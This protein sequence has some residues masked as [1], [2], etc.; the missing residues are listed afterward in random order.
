MT[1]QAL[2]R[3]GKFAEAEARLKKGLEL[4]PDWDHRVLIWLLLAMT[5]QNL[6]RLDDAQLWSQRAEAARVA[7]RLR[8][9]GRAEL[10][11][12]F[13]GTG[14]GGTESFFIFFVR[15]ARSLPGEGSLYF[16]DNVFADGLPAAS[17]PAA[18]H[19]VR[20]PPH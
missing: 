13:P 4:G 12:A 18:S 19:R 9:T 11:A 2:Y 17:G 5:D 16:P 3:C 15:E 14:V 6:G 20:T 1:G 10:I 7:E 8:G